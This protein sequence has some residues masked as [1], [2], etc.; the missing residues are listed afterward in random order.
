[1]TDEFSEPRRWAYEAISPDGELLSE[2]SRD[3]KRRFFEIAGENN[4]RLVWE[5]DYFDTFQDICMVVQFSAAFHHSRV[6]FCTS[7]YRSD[8]EQL[9]NE[10]T[11]LYETLEGKIDFAMKTGDVRLTGRINHLGH[12]HWAAEIS[13]REN[14]TIRCTFDFKSDQT[15]LPPLLEQL[16][17]MI[18]LYVR[19][20]RRVS[21][22]E[23]I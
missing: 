16:Q 19:A 8:L 9:L 21:G 5:Y 7:L 10:V 15:F 22:D 2:E 3:T 4:V 1:M 18:E 14:C 6:A 23:G 11:R 13:Y 12:I 20:E 17:N